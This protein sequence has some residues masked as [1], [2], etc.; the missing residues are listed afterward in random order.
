MRGYTKRRAYTRWQAEAR[1]KLAKH[2]KAAALL[3]IMQKACMRRVIAKWAGHAKVMAYR[4]RLL[5]PV[6]Q[7]LRRATLLHLV[8]AWEGA[9]VRRAGYRE[10]L[11]A[12]R[13][14]SLSANDLPPTCCAAACSAT[15]GC[16]HWLFY[17]LGYAETCQGGVHSP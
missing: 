17:R 1:R 4:T 2:Q 5:A 3:A 7:R 8:A 16:V 14:A 12:S 15:S 13:Q 10:R 9:A 6:L 11:E